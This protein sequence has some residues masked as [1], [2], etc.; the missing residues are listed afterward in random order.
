M[1]WESDASAH[2]VWTIR[3][4]SNQLSGALSDGLGNLVQLK[5]LTL[6]HNAITKL[7]DSIRLLENLE[8]LRIEENQLHSLPAQIGTHVT[9]CSRDTGNE[10]L[11]A[12]YAGNL[13]RLNTLTA[14]SNQITTLPASFSSL[15]LLQMLELHKN[16]LTTTGDAFSRL[17][18]LK[19]LDL[20]QNKLSVF[21]RL[22]EFD[23]A[24]DQLLLGYNSLETVPEAIAAVADHLSVL[25]LRDNKLQLLPEKIAHLYMLKTLDL[26]NNDLHDLPPGL[27]FLKYMNNLLVDGNPMRSIRRSIISD[28][29]ESLKKYLRT[30]GSPPEGVVDVLEAETDEFAV[31]EKQQQDARE[32]GSAASEAI[33]SQHEYLFRDAASSGVLQLTDMRLQSVPEL[34]E[35]RG[36]FNLGE[37]LVQLNLSKNRLG[38]LPKEIGELHA[39]QTLVAE[40]CALTS[41]DPSI[42]QLPQLQHIR[43]RKNQLTATMIN[44]WLA[45]VE[46]RGSLCFTLKE[47]D[48]RNNA[49]TELPRRLCFLETVDTLL[50]SYNRLRTLDGFPWAS[51]RSLSVLSISDNQLESIGSVYDIK[52]LTSLSIENNNLRQVG[53]LLLL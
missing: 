25:D 49:I 28:G 38:S 7:P 22:P 26:T 36:K 51:M 5:E 15:Q 53:K 40:E 52:L 31:R 11:M 8:V 2:I 50:L 34:L 1:L 48:L 18:S 24:L 39:L 46:Q 43:L 12:L 44:A 3:E 42:T 9:H 45:P 21:P 4:R 41:L 37:T 19:F 20:R 14:H 32:G 16:S 17:K 30:R 6:G 33:V 47:L 29:T 23:A 10:L 27:G 35:G 13:T